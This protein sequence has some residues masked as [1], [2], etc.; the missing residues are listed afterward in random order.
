MEKDNELALDLMSVL[1]IIKGTNHNKLYFTPQNPLAQ[2]QLDQQQE[3]I[4]KQQQKIQDLIIN[5]ADTFLSDQEKLIKWVKDNELIL[6]KGIGSFL[7]AE[8]NKLLDK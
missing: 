6:N 8:C 7:V 1:Y 4:K 5:F 3:E 2:Y